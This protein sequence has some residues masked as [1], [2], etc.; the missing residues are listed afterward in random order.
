MIKISFI[1][2]LAL[3]SVVVSQVIQSWVGIY[4]G[5]G[6]STEFSRAM[7]LDKYGNIYVTGTS[8]GN[9]TS[10]DYV[11]I[12]YN[13]TSSIP[14]WVRRY[15]GPGNNSENAEDIAVDDSGNVY[16]TGGSNFG[17]EATTIKYDN[18]GNLLWVSHYQNSDS[19][20]IGGVSISVNNDGVFIVCKSWSISG[21]TDCVTIKYNFSGS[22]QWV[23]RYNAPGNTYDEPR[24]IINDRYGNIYITGSSG[25]NSFPIKL[26]LIKYSASGNQQWIQTYS[27]PA[28]MQDGGYS[29]CADSAGNIYVTGESA[30][31]GTSLDFVTISYTST[32]VERWIQ[33]YNGAANDDDRA[34]AITTDN[35]GNII[36]TGRSISAGSNFDYCTIKYNSTGVQQWVRRY[37]GPGNDMDISYAVGTDSAGNV[38]VTGTSMRTSELNSLDMATIKYNSFGIE[39]WVQ[40]Y[41]GPGNRTDYAW[42]IGV[43]KF[44]NVFVSGEGSGISPD[45]DITTIK[46]IQPIGIIQ[47]SSEIPKTYKLSQNYPNPFNPVTN[48]KFAVAKTGLV[49]LKVYDISG[50]ETSRLVNEELNAGIYNYVFNASHLSSG[51][52]F[53]KL[54]SENFS[55]TKKMVLVK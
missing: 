52:Y 50:R 38:Y 24:D 43:D 32:G 55:E 13:N 8:V 46:Y 35:F 20:Y 6:N 49:T 36:V 10:G 4:N 33:R 48:I 19:M 44:G 11:T 30:G 37:N 15:F 26:L 51:I 7:V 16:V 5:P 53:Y 41:N 1:L 3:Q 9:G 21:L 23:Q 47:I 22:I 54:T 29:L 45:Y 14:H 31:S 34:F 28:N 42:A 17:Y 18:E 2:F 12:K 25:G 39:K 27:G 40:R